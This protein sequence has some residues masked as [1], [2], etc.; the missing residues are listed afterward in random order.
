MSN[1]LSVR[2]DNQDVAPS[3]VHACMIRIIFS[4]EQLLEALHRLRRSSYIIQRPLLWWVFIFVC[5]HASAH[6]LL[7]PHLH[8]SN[9]QPTFTSAFLF[10]VYFWSAF[11]SSSLWLCPKAEPHFLSS[12]TEDESW[13]TYSLTHMAAQNADNK[14]PPGGVSIPHRL[15]ATAARMM[16]L[17]IQ[18]MLPWFD[19]NIG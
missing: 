1:H 8:V 16:H 6:A 9:P 15:C 4:D 10:S 12:P 3:S 14:Q 13:L 2:C 18:S 19:F 17:L 5:Q 11:S 7:L